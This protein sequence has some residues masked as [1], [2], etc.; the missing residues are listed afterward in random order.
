MSAIPQSLPA[1]NDP[2]DQDP[3][4]T[5]EWL[6]ALETVL[7][8]EGPERAAALERFCRMYWYPIYAFIRRRG[9]GA[10]DA[11]DLTQEFFARLIEKD[12]LAG[13]E[14]RTARFSTLLLKMIERFLCNEY[15]RAR[16]AK[17]G[18]G[19]APLSID[20]ALAESWFGA[21]PVTDE[22]PSKGFER[23]WALAVLA[24]AHERQLLRARVGDVARDVPQIVRHPPRHDGRGM[25]V[26]PAPE[27]AEE[28]GGD[29]ELHQRSARVSDELA[30]DAEQR[31]AGLV[32]REVEGVEPPE[33]AGV[34]REPRSIE[35]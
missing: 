16:A 27:V 15:D 32:N 23:H 30:E 19:L 5:R 22:T 29:E 11:R 20:L 8:Q 26:L 17:R 35:P 10:D 14:R 3:V 1:E 33:V 7:Q 12:W 25:V 9:N 6:D 21:E 34:E 4:E 28:D 18:G 2:S 13:I 31:M 24:A